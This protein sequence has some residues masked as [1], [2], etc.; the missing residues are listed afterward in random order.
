VLDAEDYSGPRDLMKPRCR[1]R[2]ASELFHEDGR[3]HARIF[4]A[5]QTL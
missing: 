2:A 1:F 5:A 3:L 4:S